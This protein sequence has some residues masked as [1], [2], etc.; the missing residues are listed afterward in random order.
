LAEATAE[1]TR[2]F[3]I[4]VADFQMLQGWPKLEWD[5]EL[6]LASNKIET[7]HFP[8]PS[9]DDKIV[10]SALAGMFAALEE[11]RY[12]HDGVG[13][14]DSWTFNLVVDDSQ[15]LSSFPSSFLQKAD[16]SQAA[17]SAPETVAATS[18]T[19]APPTEL[20][21]PPP[22]PAQNNADSQAPD[23]T[24]PVVTEAAATEVPVAPHD[25]RPTTPPVDTAVQEEDAVEAEPVKPDPSSKHVKREFEA[26]FEIPKIR[27][28][29]TADQIA[30]WKKA[31]DRATAF[32]N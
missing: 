28:A 32:F 2:T 17:S 16:A 25:A 30:I 4:D 6:K 11:A 21:P 20:P 26:D 12:Y 19:S 5:S 3:E 22:A 15:S 10:A 24:V 7:I 31:L 18:P 29:G 9:T 13:E 14:E 1:R 27:L 8:L 23:T